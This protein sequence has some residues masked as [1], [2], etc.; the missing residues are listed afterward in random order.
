[1]SDQHSQDVLNSEEIAMNA[2]M[3]EKKTPSRLEQLVWLRE[4]LMGNNAF[5]A[6]RGNSRKSPSSVVYDVFKKRGAT[7]TDFCRVWDEF[8][9]QGRIMGNLLAQLKRDGWTDA[10]RELEEALDGHHVIE[11]ED[12][13]LEQTTPVTILMFEPELTFDLFRWAVSHK[14][15]DAVEHFTGVCPDIE[16]GS[17]ESRMPSLRKYFEK[18][19]WDSFGQA[20][21]DTVQLRSRC[22]KAIEDI[23]DGL[24]FR[25][26]Q[27]STDGK[28]FGR[29]RLFGFVFV[30]KSQ[31]KILSAFSREEQ[32]HLATWRINVPSILVKSSRGCPKL[33]GFHEESCHSSYGKAPFFASRG[34]TCG[35]GA[36]LITDRDSIYPRGKYALHL[37][38][39][40]PVDGKFRIAFKVCN[41]FDDECA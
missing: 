15:K 9:A 35:M 23:D 25:D 21:T 36:S 41:R 13:P 37:Y 32:K 8:H 30:D 17:L 12:V 1:M 19:D 28:F 14:K 27:L 2:I 18:I 38:G 33:L 3:P 34:V 16:L 7:P 39:D 20:Y 5:C 24:W 31:A 10:Y 11:G 26:D 6:L 40:K 22:R 29:G 4:K